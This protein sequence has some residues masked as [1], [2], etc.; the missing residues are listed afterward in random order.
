M[1]RFL[2][3]LIMIVIVFILASYL[4]KL[5]G[6]LYARANLLPGTGVSV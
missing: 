2:T 4:V 1:L 5:L 3:I 6:Q